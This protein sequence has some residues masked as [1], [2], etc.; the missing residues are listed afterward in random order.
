MEAGRPILDKGKLYELTGK[1]QV[2]FSLSIGYERTSKKEIETDLK[3]KELRKKISSIAK[4]MNEQVMPE[5]SSSLG[6]GDYYRD[7][8]IVVR[9]DPITGRMTKGFTLIGVVR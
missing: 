6:A 3:L 5:D 9:R 2:L 7:V 8:R 4:F 1:E